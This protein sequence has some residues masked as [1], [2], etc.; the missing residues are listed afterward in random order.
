MAAGA[1]LSDV[2]T[3]RAGRQAAAWRKHLADEW[4]T[5]P[6]DDVW[7]LTGAAVAAAGGVSLITRPYYPSAI[8]VVVFWADVTFIAVVGSRQVPRCPIR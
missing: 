2:V 3:V 5:H 1:A 6:V 7:M 8:D 4:A